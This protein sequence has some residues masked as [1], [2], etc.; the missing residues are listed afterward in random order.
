MRAEVRRPIDQH[1][2]QEREQGEGAERRRRDG[3]APAKARASPQRD[4]SDF[5]RQH[6]DD[7][8]R[9]ERIPAPE[10][11]HRVQGQRQRDGDAPRHRPNARAALPQ[12]EQAGEAFGQLER[13]DHQH[14]TADIGHA[15][16]SDRE[17]RRVSDKHGGDSE[18]E[19]RGRLRVATKPGA[20]RAIA[21]QHRQRQGGRRGIEGEQRE[22]I[23]GARGR[24]SQPPA[25]SPEPVPAPRNSLA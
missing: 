17:R 14:E 11:E 13:A 10:G 12:G 20:P 5:E 4:Q 8:H 18:R 19:N 21:R 6:D 16:R 15:A 3:V 24:L 9:G 23:D 1:R 25:E 22:S 7:S 2:A